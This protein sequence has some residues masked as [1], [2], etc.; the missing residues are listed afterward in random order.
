[1]LALAELTFLEAL[2]ALGLVALAELTFLPALAAL[3]L[4]ALAELTFLAALAALGLLALAALAFLEATFFVGWAVGF[5][6]FALGLADPDAVLALVAVFAAALVCFDVF[7]FDA[8][9]ILKINERSTKNV[10]IGFAGHTKNCGTLNDL[11]LGK[12]L[13]GLTISCGRKVAGRCP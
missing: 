13:P 10:K 5:F 8:G 9:A 11:R 2:A 6:P 7:A 4:V 12:H 1:L 3:G